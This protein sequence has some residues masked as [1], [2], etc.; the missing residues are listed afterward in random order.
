M[1][2]KSYTCNCYYYYYYYYYILWGFKQTNSVMTT[3]NNSHEMVK[4]Y[5]IVQIAFQDYF[6]RFLYLSWTFSTHHIQI[7]IFKGTSIISIY[8]SISFV[9]IFVLYIFVL[10]FTIFF[11]S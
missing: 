8:L 1:Q 5:D 2:Q 10:R 11:Q 4:V 6:Y 7:I 9:D 3:H